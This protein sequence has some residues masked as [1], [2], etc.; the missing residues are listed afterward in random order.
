MKIYSEKTNKEYASVDECLAAEKEFDEAIAKKKAEEEKALVTR[1][2]KQEALAATRK[3]RAAEVE[4][5]YK[6]VLEAK[7]AYREALD[8]FVRDYGS[9][10]MTVK[11][12]EGNP[13]DLFDGFFDH[14]WL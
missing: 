9:F 2:A 10:H 11:T 7:K 3:D 4:E 1:K 14:F 5:K 13:F 6:A 12:G 8:A